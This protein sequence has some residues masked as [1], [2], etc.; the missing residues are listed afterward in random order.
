MWHQAHGVNDVLDR[1]L[2]QTALGSVTTTCSASHL[3]RFAL[4]SRSTWFD[5]LL[6]GYDLF[7]GDLRLGFPERWSNIPSPGT[8][9][10]TYCGESASISHEALDTCGT[11]PKQFNHCISGLS[12]THP[13]HSGM[14]VPQIWHTQV[15]LMNLS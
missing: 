14:I 7:R 5:Q 10:E 11:A 15:E 1:L 8:C 12:R 4:F 13:K 2:H 3:N 9:T 6:F